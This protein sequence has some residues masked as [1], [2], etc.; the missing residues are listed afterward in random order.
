MLVVSRNCTGFHSGNLLVT[1]LMDRS[2]TQHNGDA[3]GVK[4]SHLPRCLTGCS[5]N[6]GIR[7]WSMQILMFLSSPLTIEM[8]SDLSAL[9]F[10]RALVHAAVVVRVVKSSTYARISGRQIL[11][12]VRLPPILRP[13]WWW[14]WWPLWRREGRLYSP[15]YLL[16]H[17]AMMLWSWMLWS[18]L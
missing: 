17:A 13:W 18:I 2:Q 15:W 8:L 9:I 6:L 4:P 11:F 1:W 3:A 10:I 16:L 7:L 12:L 5:D 14:W